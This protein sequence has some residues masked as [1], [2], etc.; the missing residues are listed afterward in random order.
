MNKYKQLPLQLTKETRGEIGWTRIF[1]R[2]L[3]DGRVYGIK[4]SS[5]LIKPTHLSMTQT[6]WEEYKRELA[7]YPIDSWNWEVML[8]W[9]GMKMIVR[10]RSGSALEFCP[11]DRFFAVVPDDQWQK[12][13]NT[14]NK[15]VLVEILKMG[16]PCPAIAHLDKRRA[17]RQFS[18]QNISYTLCVVCE[19]FEDRSKNFVVCSY[20]DSESLYPG[21]GWGPGSPEYPL[22]RIDHIT[23]TDEYIFSRYAKHLVNPSG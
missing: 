8:G 6:A 16:S 1:T 17:V 23:Q 3:P 14:H 2:I 13:L 15:P 21:F 9:V 18:T 11:D 22:K 19:N 20:K 4:E 10:K 7:Q 5:L 12:P